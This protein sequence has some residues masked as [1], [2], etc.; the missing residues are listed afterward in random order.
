M[1]MRSLAETRIEKRRSGEQER[2]GKKEKKVMQL[3]EDDDLDTG[4]ERTINVL[5]KL[6]N[7]KPK[8]NSS[9]PLDRH[10]SSF[11]IHPS[12]LRAPG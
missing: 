2:E 12:D 4:E 1:V 5:P 6:T 7:K 9:T 10:L 3:L 8:T 11:L